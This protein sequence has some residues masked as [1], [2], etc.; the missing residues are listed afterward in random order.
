[1]P[2]GNPYKKSTVDT[3]IVEM[4]ER[5]GEMAKWQKIKK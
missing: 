4:W 5:N 2:S 1:M 3:P